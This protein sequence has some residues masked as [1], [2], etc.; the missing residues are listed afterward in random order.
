MIKVSLNLSSMKK[1]QKNIIHAIM[2]ML[3]MG[4]LI[5]MMNLTET[6]TKYIK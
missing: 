3:M 6:F 2:D 1:R 4:I 5:T